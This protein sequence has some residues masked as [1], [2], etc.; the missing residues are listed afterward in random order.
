MT[1]D[2]R[3]QGAPSATYV[4]MIA[5]AITMAVSVMAISAC[6]GRHRG[7][8]SPGSGPGSGIDGEAGAE[9]SGDRQ[10]VAKYELE[11]MRIDVVGV[12]DSG[13]PIL[14]SYD[15]RS[16][17][18]EGNAALAQDDVDLALER[19]QLL[20][21]KFPAS[22]LVVAARYNMGLAYEARGDYDSAIAQYRQIVRTD[23]ASGAREPHEWRDTI[24]AHLRLAAVQAEIGRWA[25]ARQTLEALRRH[26]QLSANLSH[27]DRTEAAARLGY[28][29]LEQE[30]YEFADN[31]LRDGL[32]YYRALTQPIE[33]SEFAAMGYYYLA[34][35]AHRQ[36][37][38]MPLRLPTE[39][40]KSDLD[41]K[42]ALV[43][44]AYDR[45]VDV[46]QVQHPYWGTAAGYQMSQIYKELWDDI[47]AAPV[48]PELNEDARGYYVSEVFSESRV[49][50]EKALAGHLKNIELAEAYG[51]ATEWSR[52][53]RSE[54][55]TIAR[56]LAMG[57]DLSPA[58]ES[59]PAPA[60]A[61][62]P[63]PAPAPEQP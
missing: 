59:E 33:R 21:E 61:S 46:F 31:V 48:P 58:P 62:E 53:S 57:T 38:A 35:V 22:V 45:Y 37:R 4:R 30:D 55:D 49:L 50:L 34:Q 56:L 28:V 29:A 60:S 6:A 5:L 8:N 1:M 9:G 10:P 41:A 32:T 43:R 7:T 20:L 52:A 54:A 2:K 11:P 51:E 3:G 18:D 24:D 47:A 17:L 44:Q 13:D 12:D 63:A 15:A 25:D 16:L 23:G 27:S 40:M 26:P 42:T 36:A 39:Q 14:W 19:Y